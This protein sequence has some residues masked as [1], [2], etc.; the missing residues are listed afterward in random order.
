[1]QYINCYICTCL[2]LF[3]I[4]TFI[5]LPEYHILQFHHAFDTGFNAV[6]LKYRRAVFFLAGHRWLTGGLLLLAVGG[7]VYLMATTKTGFVP[8]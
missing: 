5:R 7:L 3:F 2:A 1:M 6:L 8:N 4:L